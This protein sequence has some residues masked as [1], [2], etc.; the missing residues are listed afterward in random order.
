MVY[1]SLQA[2]PALLLLLAFAH[3]LVILLGFSE[4]LQELIENPEEIVRLC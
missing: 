4:R 2:S 1:L 3:V